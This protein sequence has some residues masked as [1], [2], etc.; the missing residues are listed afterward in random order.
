MLDARGM[1]SQKILVLRKNDPAR[2]HAVGDVFFVR[3][4][5]EAGLG[6]R[7]DIDTV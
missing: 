6:G 2:G 3:G 1:E 5:Q 7:R 4:S